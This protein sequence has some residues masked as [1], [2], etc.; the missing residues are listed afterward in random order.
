MVLGGFQKIPS[1]AGTGVDSFV[2]SG[3][4]IDNLV[5]DIRSEDNIVFNG[6]DWRNCG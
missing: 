6:I 4:V 1:R 2:V 5:E 3:D